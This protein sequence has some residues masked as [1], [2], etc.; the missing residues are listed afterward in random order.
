MAG[1]NS[2]EFKITSENFTAEEL[3]TLL[4]EISIKDIELTF[5]GEKTAHVAELVLAKIEKEKLPADEIH[6]NFCID[7]LG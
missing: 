5:S 1:V 4:N 2:L 7:P 6:L 3:D